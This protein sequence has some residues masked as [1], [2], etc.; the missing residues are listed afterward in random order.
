MVSSPSSLTPC[1]LIC[2][3]QGDYCVGCLRTLAEIARWR[4]MS[5]TEKQQIMDDLKN[6]S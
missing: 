6:R 3:I 4:R 5:D 1:K 2:Q